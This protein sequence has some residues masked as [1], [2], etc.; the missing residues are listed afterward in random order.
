M[1]VCAH[2]QVYL[3]PKAV[4]GEK[5]KCVYYLSGLTCTDKNVMEKSG[6]Q[7]AAS[8]FVFALASRE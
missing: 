6:I 3:P 1:Y 4:G 5:V 2:S 7:R 8:V